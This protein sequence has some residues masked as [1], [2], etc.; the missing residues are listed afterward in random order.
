MIP[1]RLIPQAARLEHNDRLRWLYAAVVFLAVSVVA[2]SL[3]LLTSIASGF[4]FSIAESREWDEFDMRVSQMVRTLGEIDSAVDNAAALNLNR[5]S[6]EQIELSHAEFNKTFESLIQDLDEESHHGHKMVPQLKSAL[7]QSAQAARAFHEEA[8]LMAVL[9]A[10]AISS[11]RLE[12]L[13]AVSR[14][15]RLARTKLEKARD[16]IRQEIETGSRVVMRR[17]PCL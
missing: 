16:I 9:P 14:A 1:L 13:A 12:Q 17:A 5:L 3:W 2:S 6:N 7:K 4:S 10:A 8:K 11:Q 15:Y